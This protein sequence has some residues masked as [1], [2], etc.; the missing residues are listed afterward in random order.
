MNITIKD[1][2]TCIKHFMD[3]VYESS[4]KKCEV[5]TL[6][7]RLRNKVNPVMS[8]IFCE[9]GTTISVQASSGHYCSPRKD[10]PE[11]DW[12]KV[13]VGFPSKSPESVVDWAKYFDG[14]YFRED[15]TDGVYGYVPIESVVKY[16][17][18]H[19]G[20]KAND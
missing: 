5:S 4:Y 2:Y 20:I 11:Q 10:N 6:I 1:F 18:Y 14:D 16:I 9:D 8:K 3:E 7:E 19:G 17:N 13:E 12:I 15:H